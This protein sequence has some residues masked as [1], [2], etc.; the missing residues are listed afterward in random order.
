MQIILLSILVCQGI[1]LFFKTNVHLR[2]TS[3]LFLRKVQSAGVGVEA[4]AGT[5]AFIVNISLMFDK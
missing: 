3:S 4:L 5:F 2:S 1:T